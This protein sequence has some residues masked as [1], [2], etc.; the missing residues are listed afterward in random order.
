MTY[1]KSSEIE[2]K[3][4]YM[5]FDVNDIV[6]WIGAFLGTVSLVISIYRAMH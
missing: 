1:L 3:G 4:A 6:A 5:R 2:N